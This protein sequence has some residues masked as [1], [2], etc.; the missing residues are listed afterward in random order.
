MSSS[1]AANA[2]LAKVRA[3][4]GKHLTEKDYAALLSCKSVSEVVSYLKNNTY[5]ETVLRKV[6]E[7]E[8]HRG[9]LE[10]I[11]KQRLFNDFYSLCLYTKGS[12]EHFA[13]YILEKNEIEQIIH[14]LTLLSSNST[15]EYIF[16]MPT[17]FLSHTS[18][19]F[20]M[21][22]GARTY[23]QFFASLAGSPYDELM[24]EYK[25]GKNNRINIALVENKLYKYCYSNLYNSIQKYSSG[26]ERKALLSMFNSI[27][28][29]MNFVRVFRLKKYYHEKP[30]VTE[31]FLFPYGTLSK[32]TIKKLCDAS[33]SSEVFEAVS[34]TS[35][36]RSIAKLEYVYAGEIDNLGLYNITRKNIHF[37]SF[38]LV[39]MLSYVFVMETEYNNIVSI[40]EGVR[41]NVDSDKIKTIVIN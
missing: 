37:S 9:R 30:D 8:I 13:Q 28:D 4:Y 29:Y 25:V 24:A 3:K 35:F 11:L 14:F 5:Y 23:E 2:V 15:E 7:R 1:K 6:N 38:P 12:G 33:T 17:Y 20:N 19:N 22:S 39:V 41:Y 32:K 16:T 18:L 21:L 40:I 26:Q 31:K 27:M 10:I 36:G 34:G